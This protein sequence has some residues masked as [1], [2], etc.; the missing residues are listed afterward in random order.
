MNNGQPTI[1]PAREPSGRSRFSSYEEAVELARRRLPRS[2]HAGVVAGIDRGITLR[3]NS[4]AFDEIGF[5]P[6]AAVPSSTRDLSTTV[7][8]TPMSLPVLLAPVGALRLVHSD[9]V[10]AAARA[11]S[12]AGTVCV[13]S[14]VA[15]HSATETAAATTGPLWQQL[16][17]HQG[18]PFAERLIAEAKERGYRALVVTVD[19]AAERSRY[20][21]PMHMSVRGAVRYAPELIRRPRWTARFIRDGMRLNVVNDVKGFGERSKIKIASWDDFGWITEAWPG[22]LVIKGIV[23]REDALRALDVGA[24]AVVVSNHGAFM[25]DGAPATV[26]ALP[27]VL[28][29]VDGAAEVLLDS[30]VRLGSDVVKAVAIGARAVLIGRPYVMGLAISGEVGVRHMIELFRYEI[31]RTLGMMG[32]PSLTALDRSC[33]HLPAAWTDAKS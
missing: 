32:C 10:L 17:M 1:R 11:A 22:P 23:T 18:R 29:A 30:G 21:E 31:D 13:R 16:Y 15:G 6:R 28:E 19:S 4:A 26:R 24:H 8:G 12:A 2:V 33:V 25:L 27:E 3:D 7:L 9:G 20:S 14:M 5:R